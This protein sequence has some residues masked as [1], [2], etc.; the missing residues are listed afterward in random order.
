MKASKSR[1]QRAMDRLLQKRK[2]SISSARHTSRSPFSRSNQY[3]DCSFPAIPV[4][5]SL[6]IAVQGEK[7]SQQ[8]A[9]AV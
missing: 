8:G 6:Q 9:L 1:R 7:N 4:P 3:T 5:L 2:T